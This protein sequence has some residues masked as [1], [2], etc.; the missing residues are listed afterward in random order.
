M[1]NKENKRES[2]KE[3]EKK[4][5]YNH[6]RD[7]KTE[8]ELTKEAWN[9]DYSELLSEKYIVT[10]NSTVYQFESLHTALKKVRELHGMAGT[11]VTLTKVS[12]IN[13]L[14]V[15]KRLIEVTDYQLNAQGNWTDRVITHWN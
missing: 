15:I 7:Y 11:G 2:K 6:D 1:N 13:V 8:N 10:N 9:N 3:T 12:K 14:G 5:K 4:S